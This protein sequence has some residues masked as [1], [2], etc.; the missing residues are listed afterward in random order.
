[1]IALRD[2][3]YTAGGVGTDNACNGIGPTLWV[4]PAFYI[5][6]ISLFYKFELYSLILFIFYILLDPIIEYSN[7]QFS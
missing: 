1:M 6:L 3:I 5:S 2:Y 4:P 7:D